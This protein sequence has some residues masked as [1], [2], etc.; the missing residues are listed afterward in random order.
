[1]SGNY[2]LVQQ[3][4]IEQVN[5]STVT[6]TTRSASKSGNPDECLPRTFVCPSSEIYTHPID[7]APAPVALTP[8]AVGALYL[9]A[10]GWQI[11]SVDGYQIYGAGT[12]IAR[13]KY[14]DKGAATELAGRLDIIPT[15]IV[16]HGTLH[17]QHAFFDLELLGP[18]ATAA[19]HIVWN[20]LDGITVHLTPRG[21]RRLGLPAHTVSA[22][23]WPT[24]IIV[25][26]AP[27]SDPAVSG[28]VDLLDSK[29]A[30]QHQ[31]FAFAGHGEP[32]QL[33]LTFAGFAAFHATPGMVGAAA[34][35]RVAR[36]T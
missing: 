24:K 16:V 3:V 26:G 2:G 28:A 17:G 31:E 18:D 15:S 22:E 36:P 14:P 23:V 30:S 9:S 25:T 20:G 32:V 13:L 7:G 27:S 1:M 10:A 6:F 21:A 19:Q 12:P 35:N 4:K 29:Q 33:S 11:T 34:T 5:D 8:G